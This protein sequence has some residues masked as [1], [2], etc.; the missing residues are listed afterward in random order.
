[1]NRLS[2]FLVL[3]FCILFPCSASAALLSA[4]ELG[5]HLKTLNLY[6]DRLPDG[7]AEGLFSSTSLRLDLT[8]RVADDYAFELSVE[9]QLLWSD[10]PGLAGLPGDSTNQA[11]AGEHSWNRDG[12]FESQLR[13]DRLNLRGQRYG[14]DWS[15]GRQ[16]IGF[17]R[18]SLF[19]PLDVIAPFPPDALDVDV[20]PG[21]DA[22][23]ITR[24][25][26]LGGQ[27]GGVLVFGD[28]PRHNSY[29]FTFS[30]N[31]NN[32][33]LLLLTGSLR[34]RPMLGAGLAGE[35]GLLG[36]KGEVSWY[37]GTQVGTLQ[38][39]RR[40]DFAIAALE[41]WY[42][43]SGGLVLIGEY[44][45]NGVGSND[46]AQYPLVATSAPSA[47]GLS[48]LLGRHYLLLGPAYELHPLVT[49]SGLVLHN[50]QDHSSLIRPQMAISLSD[51]FQL[52]LFWAFT[53]GDKQGLDPITGLPQV[54]SEFGG[55]GDSGGLLLRWYF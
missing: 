16:A 3:W 46:P 17:G 2:L 44:L 29:L 4:T 32:L 26:G 24:F 13:L 41:G 36:L 23:K 42:R 43:F 27:L 35:V 19:S 49:A 28:Q 18:I 5:G 8:G 9:Q 15:I 31:L 37:R 7:S 21:V 55:S 40:G 10:P 22:I 54:R 20:R 38:G 45:Y 53:V 12:R 33:D 11:E 51:N 48:F 25:F 6:L 50:L 14:I 1:M 52:D 34:D 39:D 30:E 47:E